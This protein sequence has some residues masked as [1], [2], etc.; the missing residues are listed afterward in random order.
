MSK[1]FLFTLLALV[2]SLATFAQTATTTTGKISGKVVDAENGTPLVGASVVLAG[3]NKKGIYT[4]VEGRFFVTVQ[5]NKKYTLIISSI[6]YSDKEVSDIEVTGLDA[7][8]SITLERKGKALAGVEVKASIRKENLSSLYLTQKNSSSISDGISAEVIKKSPDRNTGEVLKRVSGASVQDNKFVVIRGLSE[9]YNVSMLNNAVLPSTEADKKAFAFDIIPSSVVDNLVIYKSPTPDLPGDFAGGAVKVITKDYPSHKLSELSLNIGYNS[10]TTGKNF[11]KGYP[12]GKYDQVG[13]FDDSRLIPAPYYRHKYNFVSYDN[14][15]KSATTK[16][17]PNTFGYEAAYRSIPAISV[18]YTGGNT[19]ILKNN[20]KLGYVYS[21]GYGN[22]RAVSERDRNEYDIQR[23][24]YY[25]YNTDVYDEK[26]NLTALLNVTYS[27]GKSK[28]SIKNLFNNSFIKT[29]G[30][31]DGINLINDPSKPFY[32]KSDNSEAAGNGLVNS[33][34]EGLHKLGGDWTIDWNGSY[35]YTYKNQPDQRILAFRSDDGDASK[36]WIK[37]NNENSPEIRNAGRVYSFLGENIYGA[38]ANATKQFNWLGQVQ[39]LKV[40]TM[41]NYRSRTVEVNALGYATLDNVGVTINESKSTSYSTLFSPENIDQYNLVVANIATNSTDYTGKA[42]LNAGYAMLDNKFTDNIKLTWGVRVEKYRQELAAR[43]K[44]TKTYDNTD[45]LP[46]FLFTYAV[47]NKS[48]IRVAGSQAVNRPEFREL[49]DYSVYDYDLNVA[50]RGLPTLKRSKISNADLRYEWFPGAGEILSAS[51]FYKYFNNPIEQINNGND[52]FSYANAKNA[53]TYG[54][55]IEIRKKLDFIGG[56]FF[57]QLTFYTNAAYIKGKVK[58]DTVALDNPL[59]GQSPYLI[60]GGLNYTS[61]ADDFSVNVLY[62][63]I[64]PR[65]RLRAQNGGAMNIYEKPRDVVDFQ[66]SK[67]LM[68]N[69]L[70]AKL[71][72]SDILA[73]PFTWYYKYDKTASNTNYKAADD[74]VINTIRYG[75][76]AT[77]SLKYTFGK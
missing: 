8:V 71:A 65:L 30:I 53:T 75:T 22:G 19:A 25:D 31:R 17:F 51:V 64:G 61:P 14:Q 50:I 42:L 40:G 35:G 1:K 37:L 47:N 23:S 57:Q 48:N 41:D 2:V 11:Y 34:V 39:K 54:A 69:K 38:S 77:L 60:N 28:I 7:T 67:K 20:N 52:V 73:Q 33:V 16:M 43:N 4:D 12:D 6:G 59:Q 3:D 32:I 70:E 36:Y 46:S 29:S 56:A 66:V 15:F 68:K 76:T 18:N 45:V 49:A 74:R 55:E 10:L 24:H 9:R 63:R 26:N 21:V 5:K 72:V 62:N 58:I 13:F 27:Y 44:E